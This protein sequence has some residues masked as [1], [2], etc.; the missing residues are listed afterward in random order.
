MNV[1][2]RGLTGVRGGLAAVLAAVCAVAAAAPA[3]AASAPAPVRGATSATAAAPR[4]LKPADLP[5][6]PSSA[7]TA[8]PVVS[9]QPDP[10]PPCVGA[11]LP[12]TTVHRDYWTD[13][14][15]GA[16]QL[17]VVERDERRAKEFVELL[18]R[19]LADCAAE[20]MEQDPEV[21]ATGRDYGTVDVEEGA[22]VRG[23]ATSWS[24]GG[25]DVSLF[26]VGRDGRTVTVVRWAQLGGFQDAPVA[27][28]RT[29]TRKA[30]DG[31]Y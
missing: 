6:H 18:R 27:A 13:V 24:W 11:A 15:A 14:D 10:L 29:T 31:L 25:N 5:P 28:F 9:G 21:T 8:G 17:T 23:L 2:T 7:W 3:V 4:F 20:L 19:D 16:Q 1:R 26:A 12:S 30:V 22:F